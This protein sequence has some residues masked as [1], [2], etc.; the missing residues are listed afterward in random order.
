M[1]RKHAGRSTD[2]LPYRANLGVIGSY[3]NVLI[4][5]IALMAQFY[6]A[7]YPIGGPNLDPTAFFQS[8]LAGPFLV[9]LYF[10][11]KIWSWFKRP[12]DRPMW[13]PLDKIDIWTGMRPELL[14]VIGPDASEEARRG[15]IQETVEERKNRTTGQK[16]M[17]VIH[18]II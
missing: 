8:Y 10:I 1:Y 9:F 12:E 18:N 3:I 14:A 7:L 6:V 13:V 17:N 15:S 16:I 5:V 2:E 11:W 4:S